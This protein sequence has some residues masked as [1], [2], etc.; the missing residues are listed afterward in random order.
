MLRRK[1]S[2]KILIIACII[3][4]Y[5]ITC[6]VIFYLSSDNFEDRDLPCISK[7]I[8]D[9]KIV[10]ICNSTYCDTI[11]DIPQL[12]IGQ[13][14]QVTSTKTGK[15]FKKIKCEFL[16]NG[17]NLGLETITLLRNEK[18]QKI[19][20]FGGAVTDSATMN[21]LN[22]TDATRQKLL[23]SYF[24][25]DGIEY[26]FLRVPIGGSDFSTRPY[27]YNDHQLDDFHLTKFSLANE[28]RKFK[29]PIIKQILSMTTRPIKLFGSPWSAPSWMKT[30]NNIMGYGTL[31]GTSGGQYYQTW[32]L[33]FAKFLIEYK[34]YG[35]DFWAVTA[36]N[37]PVAGYI[38]FFPFNALGFTPESQRIF[39]ENNLGP[40][41]KNNG[42]DKTKIIILDDQRLFLPVWADIVL[43]NNSKVKN[44]VDGIG[45]HWYANTISPLELLDRTHD[46][47]PDIF[48]LSTEA[49]EGFIMFATHVDL[50]NWDRGENY[51]TDI[52]ETLSHW[53]VGWV[54]WNIALDMEGGPNWANNVVDSPIIV[55]QDKDEFYKQPMFYA[56]G[57]FSKFV[58]PGCV[59]INTQTSYS[60]FTRN[61]KIQ[62]IAF[63]CPQKQSTVLIIMN[64]SDEEKTV[65]V[66][67]SDTRI[68]TV[69]VEERSINTF[70]WW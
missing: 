17:I 10:C 42:F 39:I 16:T 70:V 56:L 50:G 62:H 2:Q 14:W 55:N 37:E 15:R 58:S 49:C 46:K 34:K 11:E 36:Q 28:D 12:K 40:M 6:I 26:T 61:P 69:T 20:G 8:A 30:N 31:K 22:L 7:S 33:Y 59:V 54:D 5:F 4:L 27:T 19:F 43:K 23:H 18:K 63:E 60:N 44:Y 53:T 41:L 57:H 45:V 25:S 21:I 13:Y 29:I 65:N 48:I 3:L 38:P 68:F 47:H 66:K 52:I 32:A 64:R 35:I 67:D 51:A 9:G 1:R 24:A